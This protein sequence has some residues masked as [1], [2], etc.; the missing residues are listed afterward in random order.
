MEVD[1]EYEPK[2]FEVAQRLLSNVAGPTFWI[3]VIAMLSAVLI[4]VTFDFKNNREAWL[5]ML[6]HTKDELVAK[7]ANIREA[8]LDIE[9]AERE[10]YAR[11]VSGKKKLMRGEVDTRPKDVIAAENWIAHLKERRQSRYQE[12]ERMRQT[13]E[14]A[15]SKRRRNHKETKSTSPMPA[16]EASMSLAPVLTAAGDLPGNPLLAIDELDEES[17][18]VPQIVETHVEKTRALVRQEEEEGGSE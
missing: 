1:E 3:I 18:C 8:T 6:H 7:T 12:K 16:Q 10:A 17:Y 13:M 11:H 2:D 4:K 9:R 14:A 5:T 15:S